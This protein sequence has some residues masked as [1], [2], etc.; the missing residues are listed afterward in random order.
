MNRFLG[1]KPVS[2]AVFRFKGDGFSLQDD[3]SKDKFPLEWLIA[4]AEF[5]I[6]TEQSPFRL[7]HYSDKSDNTVITDLAVCDIDTSSVKGQILMTNKEGEGGK[8][9]F[10]PHTKN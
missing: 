2:K 3:L 1:I 4:E 9:V 8:I 5:E 6:V 10:I 7:M